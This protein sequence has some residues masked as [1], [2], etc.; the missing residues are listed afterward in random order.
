MIILRL[1]FKQHL[2]IGGILGLSI[3]GTPL[4]LKMHH[5]VFSGE[6]MSIGGT[7]EQ[8]NGKRQVNQ[9]LMTSQLE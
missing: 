6:R 5:L 7:A 4:P 3:Q 1:Y 9:S 2:G 8:E